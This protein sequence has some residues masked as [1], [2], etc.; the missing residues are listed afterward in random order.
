MVKYCSSSEN[1]LF[2]WMW[3]RCLRTGTSLWHPLF[4]ALW[5]SWLILGAMEAN[6]LCINIY[7]PKQFPLVGKHML[8]YFVFHFYKTHCIFLG[9]LNFL[10]FSNQLKE[11]MAPLETKLR[12][13]FPPC[14]TSLSSAKCDNPWEAPGPVLALPQVSP[15]IAVPDQAHPVAGSHSN[16]TT[17]I[18]FF[19]PSAREVAIERY[20]LSDFIYMPVIFMVKGE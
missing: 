12:S 13:M 4:R 20:S 16:E 10:F 5:A 7:R 8:Y 17:N 18:F 6:V 2:L 9:F 19:I 15:S 1:T 14:Q 3:R 11:G